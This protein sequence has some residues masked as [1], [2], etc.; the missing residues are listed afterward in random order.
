LRQP[1]SAMRRGIP[2]R[3]P[4]SAC[5]LPPT[6]WPS[7]AAEHHHC[8]APPICNKLLHKSQLSVMFVGGPNTRE[9]FHLEQGSEFFYQ[10]RGNMTLPTVQRGRRQVVSIPED[11]IYLLPPRIPH[12]P[13]RPDVDSLGL[14]VERQRRP[15]EL[16]CLRFYS[17]FESCDAVLWERYFRCDDLG[18]DLVPVVEEFLASE[19]CT[20]REPGENVVLNPPFQQS[21]DIEVPSPLHLPTLIAAHREE[22]RRGATMSVFDRHPETE[23]SVSLHGNGDFIG[24]DGPGE[25]M[26]MQV[27]GSSEISECGTVLG[28]GHVVV[29]PE[30]TTWKLRSTSLSSVSLILTQMSQS[31]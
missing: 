1:W 6:H 25:T 23:F 24:H 19:E 14:V 10:L 29:V 20:T 27:D 15:D 5:R 18:R 21:L 17:N 2:L 30:H 22:L 26:V 4:S 9:D 8:F 28:I 16:D 3:R 7:W 31:G 13:Q 12:S 11:H